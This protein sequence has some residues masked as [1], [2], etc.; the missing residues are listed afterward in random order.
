[1]TGSCERSLTDRRE[2]LAKLRPVYFARTRRITL[3]NYSADGLFY[4][5]K[6]TQNIQNLFSFKT[7]LP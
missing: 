7:Q 2:T 1:M 4:L 5:E 6:K 3:H